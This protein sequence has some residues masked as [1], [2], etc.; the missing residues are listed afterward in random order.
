MSNRKFS[1]S[2]SNLSSDTKVTS[3]PKSVVVMPRSPA[4]SSKSS[5]SSQRG[6]SKH[7]N[8]DS[9]SAAGE[10]PES[11]RV[12]IL[13]GHEGHNAPTARHSFENS[14]S[15]AQSISLRRRRTF[16]LQRKSSDQLITQCSTSRPHETKMMAL[17]DMGF[18]YNDAEHALHQTGGAYRSI[19]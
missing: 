1:T 2:Y 12:A 13:S 5:S 19:L 8:L 9:I 14:V 11:S 3:T 10:Y 17:L 6:G 4:A 16:S 18:A 15:S 7:D